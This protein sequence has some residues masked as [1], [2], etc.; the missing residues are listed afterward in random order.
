MI[1]RTAAGSPGSGHVKKIKNKFG[2]VIYFA[3]LCIR[4]LKQRNYAYYKK[5]NRN[6]TSC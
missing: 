1:N 2:I 3:Y 5:N 6:R 4:N